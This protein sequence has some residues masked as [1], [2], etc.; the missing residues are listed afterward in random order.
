MKDIQ[1]FIINNEGKKVIVIQG[2]G[3]VGSVMSL[4]CTN[5]LKNDYCVIGVELNNE[6]GLKIVKSFNDGIFPINAEDKNIYKLF[7][8]TRN[9]KNFL[10]TCSKNAYK[11]ADIVIVDINLDVKKYNKYNGELKSYSVNLSQFKKAISDIGNRCKEEVFILVES[12]V[13]PGTCERIVYPI[14]GSCFL[15]RN[16]KTNKLAIGHSYERVMP[17]PNYVNSIRNFHRVYSGVNKYSEN[18]TKL[19]LESIIYTDKYPLTKLNNTNSSELAKVLE[20]SYRAL[21]IAFMVEWSR[22][23]EKSSVNLYE[24]VNAIR[25]RP[26]HRNL[27]YPGVGVGGYCLTKDA[28]L[29]EWAKL[30]NFNSSDGLSISINAINTNDQMPYYAFLF[31]K[32]KIKSL[33]NLRIGLMGIS[34]RSDIGDTRYTPAFNLV[35]YL[36]KSKAKIH[37]NDPFVSDWKQ[38]KLKIEVNV[39]TFLKRKYDILII[40]TNH[41]LYK[42][43]LLIDKIFKKQKLKIFDLVGVYNKSTVNKFNKKH[44]VYTLGCGK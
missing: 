14:I 44:V 40:A 21:N 8:A 11:F 12:T 3:F 4:I 1:N 18:I 15:K 33:K 19:F 35:K 5:P 39:D 36:S 30:N 9:K 28:L 22:F 16:L 20:N 24:V 13:P 26:T 27:M 31:I 17:G 32:Q 41:T 10:A 25:K 37:L 7:T 42:N 34:Y 43:K 29:A 38:K 6:K 2:L 23:A